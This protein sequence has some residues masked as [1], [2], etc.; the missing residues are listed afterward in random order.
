MYR[1]DI[2]QCQAWPYKY[3]YIPSHLIFLLTWLL[4]TQWCL[5]SSI[6]IMTNFSSIPGHE[7]WITQWSKHHSTCI[8]SL[9]FNLVKIKIL[10]N[11]YYLFGF[12]FFFW[13]PN[14]LN[15]CVIN[16]TITVNVHVSFPT[17]LCVFDVCIKW[18]NMHL[19]RSMRFACLWWSYKYL[20]MY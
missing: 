1:S 4:L 13:V 8:W 11:G 14:N 7:L 20:K 17:F 15:F 19:N 5:K 18:I 6:S 2:Q 12:S 16:W 10:Y 3:M 9:N